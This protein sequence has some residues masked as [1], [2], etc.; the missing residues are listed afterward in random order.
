MEKSRV[1]KLQPRPGIK[2]RQPA[3]FLSADATDEEI[4]EF[5]RH[6]KQFARQMKQE[7]AKEKAKK[8]R[9]RRV[10]DEDNEG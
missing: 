4:E 5:V 7:P 1:I 2:G 6:I 10:K 3:G 9:R 8:P